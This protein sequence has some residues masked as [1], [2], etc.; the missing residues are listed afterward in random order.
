MKIPKIQEKIIKTL[1][2]I[3]SS[4]IQEINV[5]TNKG[6]TKESYSNNNTPYKSQV[7]TNASLT[8]H[9]SRS[10]NLPFLITFEMFNRNFHNY[11]VDSRA[12]SNVMP[13][14]VHEKLN[15][16]HEPYEIQIVQLERTRVK[17]TGELKKFLI[18]MFA[19]PKVYQVI[20]IIVVDIPD[21][22][23]ML[24]SQD[25]CYEKSYPMDKLSSP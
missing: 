3:S 17:V 9:R 11:M 5:G 19:N 25:W 16:K 4:S 14:K 1:Q 23:V 22:C 7:A 15:F 20:D 13:L 8:G 12:P 18:R 10:T 2:G 21:N 24:L 6:T